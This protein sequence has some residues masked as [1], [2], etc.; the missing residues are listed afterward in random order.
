MFKYLR[1]SF[2]K[3]IGPLR[4]NKDSEANLVKYF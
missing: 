2:S 1:C 3:D 4:Q